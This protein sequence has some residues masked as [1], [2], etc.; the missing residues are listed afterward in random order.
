MELTEDSSENLVPGYV[1]EESWSCSLMF[2]GQ[3]S[4]SCSLTFISFDCGHHCMRGSRV[5]LL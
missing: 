1:V 4:W 2:G 5:D 3:E